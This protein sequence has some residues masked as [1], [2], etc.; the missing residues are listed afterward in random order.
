MKAGHSATLFLVADKERVAV[1]SYMQDGIFIVEFPD[2]LVGRLRSGWDPWC[3]LRRKQF[4]NSMD[5]EF[6][7]IHAFE[8]RPATIYPVLSY[9]RSHKM[10]LVIDWNDWWG[11]GGLIKENRPGWYQMLFEPLETHY[12][13]NFRHFGDGHTV[14]SEALQDRL[15]T[16]GITENVALVPNG[17]DPDYFSPRNQ[18]EAR[19]RMGLDA[20]IPIL[21][22]TGY[23]VLS[24]LDLVLDAFKIVTE[25]VGNS[26]LILTGRKTSLADRFAKANDLE[27]NIIQTGYLSE[28]SLRD[29]VA[30]SDVCLMP[31]RKKVSNLGRFPGKL[32][33]YLS[34]GKPVVSNPVGEVGKVLCCSGGG[35]LAEEN[36][37]D[38]SD[39]ILS[40]LGDK[41]RCIEMGKAARRYAIAELSWEKVAGSLLEFYGRV[42]NSFH[43]GAS[44]NP[45]YGLGSVGKTELSAGDSGHQNLGRFE[46]VSLFHQR[47]AFF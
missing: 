33:E 27:N 31:F 26:K 35:M 34:M 4:M 1:K 47:R 7:L 21:C 43:N 6:D 39:K 24:D 5:E 13:E 42:A 19:S 2:L 12:E 25:H 8:T 14:V 9:L 45:N 38:F 30:G 3:T 11:R 36:P 29:V 18:P 44:F 37:E 28:D 20:N 40:L 10:P 23:D 22:F 16:L 17:C 32:S 15:E 46:E 41:E